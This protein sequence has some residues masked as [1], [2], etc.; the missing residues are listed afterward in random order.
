MFESIIMQS[1]IFRVVTP[2]TPVEV[3][4]RL[5]GNSS[6]RTFLPVPCLVFSS[7][8]EMEAARSPE[9]SVD[10]YR[11]T[12]GFITVRTSYTNILFFILLITQV[13]KT[14]SFHK[15]VLCP[16]REQFTT[17][18]CHV[19]PCVHVPSNH[20]HHGLRIAVP[21]AQQCRFCFVFCWPHERNRTSSRNTEG[22]LNLDH[23]H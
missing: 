22:L 15:L 6:C 3:H 10:F 21:R 9:M 11:N 7:T 8:L 4:W 19:R 23:A 5:G 18:N 12:W 16:S 1:I 20:E 17:K 2:C 14:S 13:I